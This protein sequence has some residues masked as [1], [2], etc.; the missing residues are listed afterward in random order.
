MSKADEV[1]FFLSKYKLYAK[2]NYIRRQKQKGRYGCAPIMLAVLVGVTAGVSLTAGSFG[3]LIGKVLLLTFGAIILGHYIFSKL[4]PFFDRYIN[5]D[6]FILFIVG[7]ALTY[8]GIALYLDLSEV[9]GAFLAGIMIAEVRRTEK[10]EHLIVPVR[11]LTLPLFF[12]YFGTTI[13]FGEGIP[14]IDLLII[15][16]FW[17]II[18]KI[19]VGYFGGK[20]YGLSKRVALRAGFSLTQRGEFSIIIASLAPFAYRAFSSIFILIS[21]IVGIGLFQLAPKIAKKIFGQN[22]P[23]KKIKMPG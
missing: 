8:G 6:I 22:K 16:I 11:D 13:S 20:M 21:A 3:L 5:E 10:L 19:I 17:S 18:A 15:L 14:N 7:A 2:L 12:L 23:V 9:L 1:C 4:G